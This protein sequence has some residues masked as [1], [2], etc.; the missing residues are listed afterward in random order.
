VHE[1]N[2]DDAN[3][4]KDEWKFGFIRFVKNSP[5]MCPKP[6]LKLLLI[7]SLCMISGWSYSQSGRQDQIPFDTFFMAKTLR[8]DYL[9]GGNDKEEIVYFSGMRQEPYWGGPH[10]NLVDPFDYGTYRYSLADSATGILIF[11][12]GFGSLFQEWKGTAEAKTL[13]KAFPM[14]AV[15]PFPKKSV[16]FI[17]EK[18][19]FET[20]RFEPLFERIINPSDYFISQKTIDIFP[21]TLLRES[22]DPKDHLD[23]AILAEGYTSLGMDKFREDARRLADSLLNTNPYS[24]NKDRINIRAV[25]SPSEESGVEIPGKGVYINTNIGSTFYT[26]GTDR[27]L[28][29]YDS[30]AIYNIAANVPYDA[31]L[32]LVNSK[33]YGGGGFYNLY[34]ESTVDDAYSPAVVAHEFGHSFAGLGDEYVGDVAYTGFYNLNV[35]PWEPNLT[36]NRQ[37]DRKWK[38]LVTAG[39][40]LPT[41]RSELYK[42][43]VGMFEGGGYES[44]GIFSPMMDCKMNTIGALEF[45]PACR[46]AIQKMID[47]YCE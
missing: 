43:S 5:V 33:K 11:R 4:E 41:P 36:T 7:L 46:Q 31:I 27:Y 13:R 45:C 3:D 10:K 18:R 38:S 21:V 35:E 32:I 17:I 12:R 47:F 6:N 23:I 14:V 26:F 39:T 16:K 42:H 20:N 1:V 25:E 44:K 24:G 8:V 34:C 28:T 15:M 29:A 40:P 2:Y 19:S 30:K 22:G 37:F 9:L